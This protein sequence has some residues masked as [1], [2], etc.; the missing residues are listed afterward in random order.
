VVSSRGPRRWLRWVIGAVAVIVVLAV[1]GPFVYFHF[2]EGN[3]PAPLSLKP[4]A[5]PSG[6]QSASPASG[7]A[8]SGSVAGTWKMGSGS[9][10]GY[11][12][13]EILAGQ[14]HTAVGR[15]SSVTGSMAIK[16]STVKTAS[17]TVKMA[18]IHTDSAQRDA[19]F[20]GRIMDVARYPD[21]TFALTKPI[22]LAPLP[23]AGRIRTYSATGN[24]TLHGQTRAVT[25][26]VKTELTS[27][28]IEVQGSIP[29]LFSKWGIPNPSFTGFVTTQNHG[30]M[31]FLL[32]FRPA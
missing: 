5:S 12:V 29:V 17:F 32:D 9:R 31:E 19:Q 27:G 2:I 14:S 4:G 26:P 1:A 3:S 20:D 18:T 28:A 23:P 24:L 16:G 10:V 25:F 22:S 15:S 7:P 21:G 11:R 13:K 8:A 30:I 6:T